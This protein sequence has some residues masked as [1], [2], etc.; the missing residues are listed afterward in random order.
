MISSLLKKKK[1][2]KKKKSKK[3]KKKRDPKSGWRLA[4]Q[5]VKFRLIAQS[6]GRLRLFSVGS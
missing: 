6:G 3:K 2:K 4:A 5:V 1:K